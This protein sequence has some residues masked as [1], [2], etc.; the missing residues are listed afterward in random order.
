MNND[1]GKS[2]LARLPVEATVL[3]TVVGSVSAA[4]EVLADINLI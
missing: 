3:Y 4:D 1:D 2:S